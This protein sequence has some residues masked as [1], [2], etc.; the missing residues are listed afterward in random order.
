MEDINQSMIVQHALPPLTR[1]C[2][3]D[4]FQHGFC[5]IVQDKK[6]YQSPRGIMGRMWKEEIRSGY[7]R[8]SYHRHLNV[9]GILVSW[10][11]F[12]EK[13][14]T[15]NVIIIIVLILETH[16]LENNKK[17]FSS[18][19]THKVEE[20][21]CEYTCEDVFETMHVAINLKGKKKPKKIAS[22]TMCASLAF[23]HLLARQKQLR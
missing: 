1:Q 8:K 19:L 3:T 5:F 2:I 21:A 12:Q 4:V 9:L 17:L 16:H 6:C 14:K 10:L 20:S 23:M 18:V 13:N 11:L 15:R 22:I 7:T